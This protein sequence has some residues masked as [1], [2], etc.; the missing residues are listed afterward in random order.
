MHFMGFFLWFFS[1]SLFLCFRFFFLFLLLF[2]NFF[3]L[4]HWLFHLNGLLWGLFWRCF[5]FLRFFRFNFDRLL[6]LFWFGFF[7]LLYF[8]FAFAVVGVYWPIWWLF[9]RSL[10]WNH[11]KGFLIEWFKNFHRFIIFTYLF[12]FL[13]R[14]KFI[15]HPSAC[16]L[17]MGFLYC[18]SQFF[19]L[20]RN[21]FRLSNWIGWHFSGWLYF[22]N[23]FLNFLLALLISLFSWLLP[24]HIVLL[25]F[26][27]HLHVSFHYFSETFLDELI[28]Q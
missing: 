18:W 3:L 28:I 14:L 22:L 15:L 21:L 23:H 5:R 25:D 7:W 13:R 2:H 11:G 24:F 1:L 19:H 20:F 16:V 26:L 8:L 27:V 9:R 10:F 12:K 6:Y 17:V 4:Y